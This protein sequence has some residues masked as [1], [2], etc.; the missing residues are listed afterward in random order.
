MLMGAEKNT[1]PSLELEAALDAVK[2]SKIVKQE[3][4]LQNTPC[5]F[6]TDSTIVIHSPRANVKKFS[7]FP[8]NRLEKL[9]TH[10]K[11]YDWNF[12]GTKVN[13]ADKLT[14]KMSA[15]LLA[16]DEAWFEGPSF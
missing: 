6:S 14:R 2:L 13:P 9:L 7:I 11:L 16:K 8:R 4:E 15:K 10:S 1:I 12:V 5:L 3:L